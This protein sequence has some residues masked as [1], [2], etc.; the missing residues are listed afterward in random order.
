ME[1]ETRFLEQARLAK[2]AGLDVDKI[3]ARLRDEPKRLP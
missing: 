1:A 3:M 2:E